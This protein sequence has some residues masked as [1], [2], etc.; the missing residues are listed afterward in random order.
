[1]NQDVVE[2][3]DLTQKLLDSVS[4]QD[5]KLYRELC[6]KSLTCFEPEAGEQLIGGLDFHKF[7]FDNPLKGFLISNLKK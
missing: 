6:D 5:W 4:R 7:Y 3:L 1:M 2:L